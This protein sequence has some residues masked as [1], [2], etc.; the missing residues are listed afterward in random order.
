MNFFA[1][2]DEYKKKLPPYLE[3]LEKGE[4][5]IE[6][7]LNEDSILEDI[8]KNS[9]SQFINFF[10]NAQIKK[11]IDYATR[12]PI[13]SDHNIGYKYPFNAT[14]LLCTENCNFQN[15]LMSEKNLEENNDMNIIKQIKKNKDGFIFQLFKAIN[16]IKKR[17]IN[18]NEKENEEE[19]DIYYEEEDEDLNDEI[20]YDNN[21]KDKVNYNDNDFKI[22]ENDDNTKNRK[23]KIIYENI[24]YLLGFLQEP[25]ETKENYVLSGYF[26][27]ILNTL[28]N[29]HLIKIVD[30][31]FNYPNKDKLDIL[32]LLVKNMNRKSMCNIIQKLLLFDEDFNSNLEEKKMYLLEKILQELDETNEKNKYECICESLSYIMTNKQFF[33]LFMKKPNLLEMLYT[34]LINSKQNTYKVNSIIKLLTKI[35]ENILQHFEIKYTQTI[36]DNNS[37]LMSLNM[38]ICNISHNKSLS[39]PE[40]SNTENLKNFLLSLFNILEKNNFSFLSD[41]GGCTQEEN[42]EF[43]STYLEPQKKIGIK[44]IIQTEYIK[45]ILDILVNSY[46]SGYHQNLIEKLINIANN[47]KI[48]WNLHN[49]FFLFPFSN[50]YQNYYIQIMEIIINDKSPNCLIELFFTDKIENKNIIDIYIDKVINNFDFIFKLTGA[51]SL[52]PYFAFIITLLSK[53]FTCQNLFL[54]SIIEKNKDIS[55]FNDIIGKEIQ[56]IFNQKLLLSNQET[57]FGDIEDENLSSFGPKSFL[58]LLE[59]DYNIYKAY[60]NGENYELMLKE[61]KERQEKEKLEEQKEKER[62]KKEKMGYN[63]KDDN[64]S[65]FKMEKNSLLDDKDNFLALLN[66]PIDE[67]YKDQD[68]K[69]NNNNIDNTNDNKKDHPKIDIKELEE[70]LEENNNIN[71]DENE[72]INKEN[73]IL[74]E[75]ITPNSLDNKIY[76]IEYHRKTVDNDD[77][78]K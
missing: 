3:K 7:I 6:D 75:D 25:N 13:S 58:E 41:L 44:K 69:I 16:K 63:L 67:V 50:I 18:Q 38:D 77:E 70:D 59:E 5:T 60:K 48:F 35:N 37:T 56:E 19:E 11:L 46:A 21:D 68:N 57:M 15:K 49:L 10:T 8:R 14:E 26:Y 55:I 12:F 36:P 47:Q 28:I 66:K 40:D 54:K 34:T 45:T 76:H 30:Y 33:D 24:D 51:R 2:L 52:N 4:L 65:L 29:V 73:A 42:V 61:K 20:D 31:L 53:I 62:K 71:A 74:N 17:E 22:I 1:V 27:K 9:D 72:K 23:E 78:K 43:I 64:D 32:D 39:S